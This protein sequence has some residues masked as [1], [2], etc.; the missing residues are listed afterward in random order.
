MSEKYTLNK[1]DIVKILT[2]LGIAVG[3]A[4]LTYL[5]EAMTQI[6]FG[7]WTPAVVALWSVLVNIAR[8]FLA[9]K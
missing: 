6:D 2:G 1:E 8:K 3:G 5:S 7:T 9:G 4:A